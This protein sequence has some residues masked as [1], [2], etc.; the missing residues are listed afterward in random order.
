MAE[1]K[2]TRYTIGELVEL[3]SR[4]L[5]YD[6]KVNPI[7]TLRS[8]NG[9]DEMKRQNPNSPKTQMKKLADLIEGCMVEKPAISVYDMCIAD[10][11]FLLHKLRVITYGDGYPVNVVCPHPGCHANIETV[12]HLDTLPVIEIDID[13]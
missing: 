6:K 13:K 8:M 9:W 4:G 12:A 11:Q 2:Q 1:E 10:Y 3:P 5:I 7:I